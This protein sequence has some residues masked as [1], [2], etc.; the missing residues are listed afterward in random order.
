MVDGLIQEVVE[1]VSTYTPGDKKIISSALTNVTKK[2]I[3]NEDG[4]FREGITLDNLPT[5][6]Y[7]APRAF[8]LRLKNGTPEQ[9]SAMLKDTADASAFPYMVGGQGFETQEEA[10]AHAKDNNISAYEITSDGKPVFYN[11]HDTVEGLALRKKTESPNYNDTLQGFWEVANSTT[12][13]NSFNTGLTDKYGEVVDNLQQI[14][15]Q[16]P[17]LLNMWDALQEGSEF[18]TFEDFRKQL[19]DS[20]T[21]ENSFK[22]QDYSRMLNYILG[23]TW[24]TDM[25]KGT[26]DGETPNN[27]DQV[28]AVAP[29]WIDILSKKYTGLAEVF[30][31][32]ANGEAVTK[33][34]QVALAN[35]FITEGITSTD[36][37]T[38]H[39]QDVTKAL[40]GMI[41]PT[42][43]ARLSAMGEMFGAVDKY[44]KMLSV[45]NRNSGKSGKDL[46]SDAIDIISEITSMDEPAI[47]KLGAD[48]VELILN[49]IT[50]SANTG[51]VEH[52]GG[53]IGESLVASIKAAVGANKIGTNELMKLAGINFETAS[54]I[55][56]MKRMTM[57][58]ALQIAAATGNSQLMNTI[59]Y[60]QSQGYT[61]DFTFDTIS[62]GRGFV[63]DE[64]TIRFEGGVNLENADS[65]LDNIF[66]SRQ[67]SID[68][69]NEKTKTM[70]GISDTIN[71]GT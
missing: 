6:L 3:Y 23:D 10:L 68:A 41:S 30:T 20:M 50:E 15:A 22:H 64:A 27:Y 61:G 69:E 42:A 60:A 34:E 33:E 5:Y 25:M 17:D 38:Q 45:S 8:A 57:D 7:N 21:G 56:T 4:S 11:P 67:L 55:F 58:Q 12:D 46:D 14:L 24:L 16:Y 35:A 19:H 36:K 62:T 49:G 70:A 53:V 9:R 63:I 71:G 44:Q 2:E 65:L 54:S 28:K 66:T 18:F 26:Y 1:V 51:A 59:K 37:Y 31:R 47:R 39:V 13:I 32:L 29:E 52:V 40:E 48:V 43:S